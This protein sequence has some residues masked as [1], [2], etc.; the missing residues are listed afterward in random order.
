MTKIINGFKV[1]LVDIPPDPINNYEI[2]INKNTF[3]RFC[4][5][6]IHCE[7]SNCPFSYHDGNEKNK[8][9]ISHFSQHRNTL[10]AKQV[11]GLKILKP[12]K[13]NDKSN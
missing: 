7:T 4:C 8:C 11:L 3:I 10:K 9:V 13:S 2:Y 1:H 12:R 6:H 5:Y